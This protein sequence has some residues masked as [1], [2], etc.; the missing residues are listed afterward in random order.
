MG[1]DFL[2]DVVVVRDFFLVELPGVRLD[3][4][5]L[6]AEPERVNTE[7]RCVGDV[8]LVAV[9]EVCSIADGVHVGILRIGGVAAPVAVA[10]VAFDLETRG[11]DA[12]VEEALFTGLPGAE[13]CLG[14]RCVSGGCCAASGDERGAG[15]CPGRE[16]CGSCCGEESPA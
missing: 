5:P 3:A 6:D 9:A 7:R 4:R 2:D 11:G 16:D 1:P 12:P 10:I 15:E 14:V 13:E 8:F